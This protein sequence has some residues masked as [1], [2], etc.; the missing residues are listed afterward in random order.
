MLP[1]LPTPIGGA[2]VAPAAGVPVGRVRAPAGPTDCGF[3]AIARRWG[4][5]L[6]RRLARLQR[7]LPALSDRGPIAPGSGRLS[8]LP[9][10]LAPLLLL[11]LLLAGCSTAAQPP[12]RVVLDAL[13]LQI[14]L[15]QDQVSQALSLP[16]GG[17]PT[18]SRVRVEQQQA[19]AIGEA[20]GLRL[21]GRFD[22]RLAEDPIRVDSP[23][24]LYLQRGERG[25]SWRLARPLGGLEEGEQIWLTEPLPLPGERPA[26]A[27]AS[28]S[29]A[30]G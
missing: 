16:P 26:A 19:I 5:A 10:R 8:W 1:A 9:R 25:Q 7:A 13:T 20:R 3:R 29:D 12:R 28:G 2:P 22:W 17:L 15:T 14:R 4:V 27:A 30:A 21:S 6:R 24:E 23:F 18:V 11:V